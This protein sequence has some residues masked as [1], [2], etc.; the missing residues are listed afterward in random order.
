MRYPTNYVTLLFFFL[1]CY[2]S[3]ATPSSANLIINEIMAANIEEYLDPSVNYGSWVELYNPTSE[4]VPLGGLYVTDDPTNLKKHRLISNYGS[5]SAHGYGILGFDHFE[6]FTIRSYRQIDDKLNVEGGTIIISDGTNIIAQQD[7]PAAVARASYARKV[8]GGSEWGL[9]VAPS[10][11]ASNTTSVFATVSLPTPEPS[12]QGQLFKGSLSF[13]VPIPTG[14]TLRYTTDGTVP[15]MT[16]GNTSTTGAFTLNKTT[17]YRFRFFKDGNLPSQVVARSFILNNGNEPFPI[18]SVI[19]NPNHIF[20]GTNAIF[21]QSANGRKGNGQTVAVNQNMDWDRPVNFEYIPTT[22]VAVINQECDFSACGGWSRS[23]EPHSFKLK[24]NK[25]Y[26]GQNSFDYPFFDEKPYIKNRTLQIRN[27]GNDNWCRIKDATMQEIACRS[28]LYVDHQAYQPVRVYIN[29]SPY[30]VLNMREP[31]NKHYAT[32]N[33]GLDTD[34]MDQFE[35]CPDS[36][37]VQ[38]EGTKEAFMRLYELSKTA[39]TAA[40]YEE[41][42]KLVDIDE[43]IN[44]MAVQIY[45]GGTDW[46]RNNIKGFR[47]QNNGKF[48]FVLFDLDFAG[49]TNTPL[50]D[51]A[52]KKIWTFD[53]L[54]GYDYSKNQSIEGVR[55]KKEI[56]FVTIFLNMLKNASFKRQF[57]DAMCLMGGSVYTPERVTSIVN[58][59]AAYVRQ[60]GYVDPTGTANDI[61]NKFG[62]SR[63]LN[64]ANHVRSYGLTTATRQSATFSSNIPEASIT[65]NGQPVPTGKFSGYIFAPVVL[66]AEAPAGYKFVGWKANASISGNQTTLFPAATAWRYYDKGTLDGSNWKS[67]GYSDA[68][69]SSGNAPIGY[70]KTQTTTTLKNHPCYYYRKSVSISQDITS[71]T[72]FQLNWT[73]DDGFVVYV[74]GME[75]ARYNMPNGTPVYNTLASTYANGNPDS[76]VMTLDAK[77]FIKGNNVIAVEVH[78]NSTSS[79]DIL[80]Q[81][82]LTVDYGTTEVTG[83]TIVSTSP[84]YSLPTTGAVNVVAVWEKVT[85]NIALK[86]Q[87]FVPIKINE[88]SAGNSMAIN[89]YI[90]KNDWVEL[91]NTT[92]VT[93]DVEGLCISDNLSKPAKYTI[94][95]KGTANTKIEPKGHLLVWC[96]KLD[97]LTQLHASFKLGNDAVTDRLDQVVMISASKTFINN[98]KEYFDAHPEM[99]EFTD[100]LMYGKH[101]GV[102]SVGRYPD[103]SATYFVFNHPTPGK[104]NSRQVSD[105]FMAKD[106]P[107]V[108]PTAIQPVAATQQTDDALPEELPSGTTITT[109]GGMTVTAPLTPGIYVIKFPDGRVKKIVVKK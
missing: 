61:K 88:V 51:F 55:L 43:Y 17:V 27:G 56:E 72:K 54:H 82:D 95:G 83:G 24:A 2:A 63:Q 80:W 71:K 26:N 105:V 6:V 46:P 40:T 93:L 42:K 19:S 92:D 48:H 15:T 23:F 87:R 52:N 106:L 20:N 94:S 11:G 90:K 78:N 64:M 89:E 29:G 12:L 107:W 28:G 31:N 85:D 41:I 81:A 103:G 33:Y 62:A 66:Q 4:S 76:G 91:Y 16:N 39:S 22:G 36:G 74:N 49:D 10:P 102:E 67:V 34:F 18:I 57:V 86:E 84:A 58:E 50:T 60:G 45:L 68:T 38:K 65:Y 14:A 104:A 47:D 96:D 7:Y 30:A 1:C 73:A 13:N 98:N 100:T 25:L 8:D 9:T 108:N 37:Y 77:Y 53:P 44:Y 101:L 5:V 59:I 79:S 75:A 21:A 35:I 32:A 99:K 70:G 109:L 69:W 3:A 97:P